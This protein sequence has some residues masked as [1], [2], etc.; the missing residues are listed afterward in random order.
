VAAA[1]AS[2]FQAEGVVP[3]VIDHFE[4]FV[5]PEFSRITQALYLTVLRRV[6]GLWGAA[7][8][9][10]DHLP[11]WSPL[12]FGMNRLG[13][14]G[15]SRWIQAGALSELRR[16][17]VLTVPHA[18]VFTDFVAHTQWIFPSVDWY[19]VPID[20]VRAGLEERG[21]AAERILVSGI[22]VMEE[23]SKPPD[24]RQARERLGL[25]QTPFTILLMAG[26]Q[27]GV[28]RLGSALGVL[29]TLPQPVQLTVVCGNDGALAREL[30]A[31]W[32]GREGVRILG[33]VDDIHLEMAAADL[34][35][36]KAGAVTLAEA[37][38][39]GLPVICFGSLPG[40]E[41]RNQK[42]AEMNGAA[43]VARTP[44]ALRETVE[45][46]RSDPFLLK[47]LKSSAK[48]LAHPHSAQAIARKLLA[49]IP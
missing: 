9:L 16:R 31:R 26:A 8:W 3:R 34:L 38:A 23:F 25:S 43:L 42:A 15:Q 24:S 10:S 39:L 44:A 13:M 18:T 46:L 32:G 47:K 36:T 17:G 30:R 12:L 33:Y 27:A 41:I 29:R 37:F 1:L 20:E 49:S 45:L 48:L 11:V 19:C 40:H 21:I 6:P 22:P 7:Y 5:S 28:G 2:A 35:I 4:S 14:R